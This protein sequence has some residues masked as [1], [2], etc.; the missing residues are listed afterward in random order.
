V[1]ISKFAKRISGRGQNFAIADPSP[2]NSFAALRNF[3]DPP[4]KGGSWIMSSHLPFCGEVDAR[5]VS[6]HVG[7][8]SVCGMWLGPPPEICFANFDLPTRGR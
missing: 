7:W 3:V 8:G 6:E 5:S 1:P 2:K 4:S